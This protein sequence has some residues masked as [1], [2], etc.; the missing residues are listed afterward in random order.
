M[1]IATSV[2]ISQQVIGATMIAFGTSLPELTLDLKS[3]LRGHS[4]LAF[5]D[6]IGSSFMN[7]T[8]ILGVTF[9]VPWLVG[10]PVIM[11]MNVFQN[12]MV[13]S[14]ITN[15][16]FWYFLSREKIGWREGLIF[17]FIY[18]LFLATTLGFTLPATS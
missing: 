16:F 9:F 3:F 10:T 8:L 7:I 15:L 17:I 5:G 12:L 1:F 2:G 4:G 14:I 6:I 13:F 18:G 11:D